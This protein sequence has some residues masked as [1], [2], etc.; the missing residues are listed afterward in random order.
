MIC[1]EEVVKPPGLR[2]IKEKLLISSSAKG[3]STLRSVS[4]LLKQD[5]VALLSITY[6]ND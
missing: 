4:E 3:L 6:Y 1:S 2:T 5:P